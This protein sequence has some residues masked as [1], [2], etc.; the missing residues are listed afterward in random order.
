MLLLYFL[1]FSII[2]Y[3]LPS[4]IAKRFIEGQLHAPKG[5]LRGWIRAIGYEIAAIPTVIGSSTMAQMCECISEVW[6]SSSQPRCA[7][8]RGFCLALV[9]SATLLWY[10]RKSEDQNNQEMVELT[11]E[12][13]LL[14]GIGTKVFI[15]NPRKNLYLAP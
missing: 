14:V 11:S 8:K 2:K 6:V 12:G 7:S 1:V 4:K 10:F 3:I 5:G 9:S 15:L 13:V